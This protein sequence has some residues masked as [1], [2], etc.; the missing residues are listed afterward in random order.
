MGDDDQPLQRPADEERFDDDFLHQ[1]V[2]QLS[3]MGM[4]AVVKGPKGGVTVGLTECTLFDIYQLFGYMTEEI[5]LKKASPA[6]LLEQEIRL[7][8]QK[9]SI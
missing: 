1:V 5:D 3:K 7:F 6:V 9:C 8:L 4:V 2:C